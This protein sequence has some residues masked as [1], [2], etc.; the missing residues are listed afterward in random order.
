MPS[1]YVHRAA[2]R[3]R[4]ETYAVGEAVS[5]SNPQRRGLRFTFRGV[6]RCNSTRLTAALVMPFVASGVSIEHMLD[7]TAGELV[8]AQEHFAGIFFLE[9]HRLFLTVRAH[10]GLDAR[11]DRTCDF[12][13]TPHIQGVRNGDHQHTRSVDMR[14]NENGWLGSV[15]G[16]GGH[17]ALA[18]SFDDLTILLGNHKGYALGGQCFT[19]APADAAVTYQHDLAAQTIQVHRH[20]QHRKRIVRTFQGLCEFRA[21][22]NPC[23]CRL[24]GTENQWVERNRDDCSSQNEALAFGRRRPRE[25]PRL[26]R[27]NDNSPI[28]ARLAETVSAVLRGYRKS[29]TSA[30][31]ASDLP[32]IMIAIT[33]ITRIGS[34][35]ST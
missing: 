12:D 24:D 20:R 2:D 7:H 27:M 26:A 15:A 33:S 35:S 14:L 17:A 31:A 23:L 4:L 28:C 22:A 8:L 6:I 3:Y 1:R 11:V 21:R 13:H 5:M 9:E 30:K 16:D 29:S 34:L 32:N 18:Q 25:T 10:H 19:D